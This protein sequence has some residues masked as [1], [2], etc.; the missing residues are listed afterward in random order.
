MLCEAE[1]PNILGMNILGLDLSIKPGWAILDKAGKLIDSGTNVFEKVESSDDYVFDY[2][3]LDRAWSVA[4]F[5]GELL[6]K[7][8]PSEIWIEQTNAGSW[9]NSQKLLEFIH[10]AVL[11]KI[12]EVGFKTRVG[13]VDTSAWTSKLKIRMSKEDTKHNKLVK[14][15]KARGK[16]TKKHL[17]VRWANATFGLNF[18]LKDN[19][20][21]EAIAVASFGLLRS[22]EKEEKKIKV[23]IEEALGL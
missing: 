7:Y 18:K 6:E 3:Q 23:S 21:A 16:I 13:Y 20:A 9:R 15:K 17:S 2:T 11:S 22:T 4:S 1:N 12:E 10:F 14:A 19:D 5:V 8:E